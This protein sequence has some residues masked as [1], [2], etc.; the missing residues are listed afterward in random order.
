[1]VMVVFLEFLPVRTYSNCFFACVF[2][3]LRIGR[4]STH[5]PAAAGVFCESFYMTSSGILSY[6]VLLLYLTRFAFGGGM[7]VP[8]HVRAG[9]FCAYYSFG[10]LGLFPLL[11]IA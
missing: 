11:F 9:V 8:P 2:D 10:F 6:I 3:A 5:A 4:V 1:M 7:G